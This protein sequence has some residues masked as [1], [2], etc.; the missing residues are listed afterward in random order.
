MAS[1]ESARREI[2]VSEDLADIFERIDRAAAGVVPGIGL[3][4]R[5]LL[6]LYARLLE[7]GSSVT[8]MTT[9]E[10]TPDPEA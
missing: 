7:E 6:G 4:P 10:P 8:L 9:H 2:V 1:E 3:P 5:D